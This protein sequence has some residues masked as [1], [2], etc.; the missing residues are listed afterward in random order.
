MAL[1]VLRSGVAWQRDLQTAALR[2]GFV[3]RL[4]GRLFSA[5]AAAAWPFLVRRRSSDLLHALTH[6]VDRAG[7]GALLLIRGFGRPCVHARTVRPGRGDLPAGRI[8]HVAGGRRAAGRG[9]AAV[10]R[11][12]AHGAGLTAHGRR[13]HATMT[14]FL[15]GLKAAKSDATEAR[16]VRDFSSALAAKR[17]EQLDF[18]RTNNAARAVFNVGGAAALAA[19]VG[20][21]VS[22]A[23]LTGPELLVMAL[24]AARVLPRLLRVQQEAQQ[25]VHVLPAWLHILEMERALGETAEPATGPEAPALPLERE[26]TLRGVAFRYHDPS[27]PAPPAL[28]GVDLTIPAQGVVAI[29]GPSGAGKTTLVDLLLGLIEPDAGELRCGRQTAGGR[30]PASVASLGCLRASG[31]PSLSRDA[32]GEPAPRAAGRHR[33]RSHGGR[34]ASPG[35]RTSSPPYRTNSKRWPVIAAAG[36]PAA[37]A[38]GSSSR[39]PSCASR[40]CSCSTRRR[41]SSTREPNGRFSR[42]SGRCRFAPPWWR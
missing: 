7:R 10:R 27:S 25:L 30:T 40:P 35:P 16:H 29:T 5:T 1:A 42:R 20:V 23:G 24:I 32:A 3:D 15:G 17:R 11:S 13:V 28:A 14:E 36:C 9:P 37:N 41:A 19:L 2:L 12:R 6:D 21:S 22:W 33:A 31:S 26:M 8:R 34:S 39:A 38:S 18:T 4:R